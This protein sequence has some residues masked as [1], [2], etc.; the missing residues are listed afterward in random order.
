MAPKENYYFSLFKQE[1]DYW[2]NFFGLFFWEM[3]YTNKQ[4]DN[5]SHGVCIISI[6]DRNATINLEKRNDDEYNEE[7]IKKTA[8][9][10]IC[11]LLLADLSQHAYNTRS[12]ELLSIESSE[13]SI[14]KI[15]QNTVYEKLMETKKGSD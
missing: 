11:D 4:V 8:F 5:E 6:I 1:C 3:N 7:T 9:H 10:E 2:I 13:H 15:L 12:S 14:I